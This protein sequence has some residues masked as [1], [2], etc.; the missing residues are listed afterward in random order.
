MCVYVLG[1]AL[2][3]CSQIGQPVL[4]SSSR[5]DE[6][7]QRVQHVQLCYKRGVCVPMCACVS[8]DG[9]RRG[10]DANSDVSTC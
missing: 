1:A 4:M 5:N 9:G 3:G 6:K 8:L 7:K 10:S 2:R